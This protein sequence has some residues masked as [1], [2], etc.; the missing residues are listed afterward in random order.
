MLKLPSLS[1]FLFHVLAAGVI[2]LPA[3]RRAG[4]LP[5]E[6]VT[7][8]QTFLQMKFRSVWLAWDPS[9]DEL[10]RLVKTLPCAW[11]MN[12][13]KSW[14]LIKNP[15]VWTWTKSPLWHEAKSQCSS[16]PS[17][18]VPWRS[19]PCTVLTSMLKPWTCKSASHQCETLSISVIQSTKQ[20]VLNPAKNHGSPSMLFGVFLANSTRWTPRHLSLVACVFAHSLVGRRA[21]SYTWKGTS[22]SSVRLDLCN[23]I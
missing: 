22:A 21:G 23:T 4:K 8:M 5:H 12:K 9:D 3:G 1:Q 19:I 6:E 2:I 17:L 11:I 7:R 18:S 13:F 15:I 16:A 20:P 14:H 10:P